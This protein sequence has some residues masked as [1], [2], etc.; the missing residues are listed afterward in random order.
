MAASS[1]PSARRAL[2]AFHMQ[3]ASAPGALGTATRSRGRLRCERRR[4]SRSPLKTSHSPRK[5]CS[6]PRISGG[7]LAPT[8]ASMSD[9]DRAWPRRA[10]RRCRGRRESLHRRGRRSEFGGASAAAARARSSQPMPSRSLP[11]VHQ[12]KLRLG[13]ELQRRPRIDLRRHS[14]ATRRLSSMRRE[15]LEVRPLGPGHRRR[16]IRCSAT[17][18]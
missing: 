16:A 6:M 13:R 14:S 12:K 2:A 3:N 9:V 15:H 5:Q 1:S 10:S 18:R 11:W 17:P 7:S 4:T 8:R